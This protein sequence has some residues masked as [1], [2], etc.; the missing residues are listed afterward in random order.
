MDAVQDDVKVSQAWP[1][2]CGGCAV[3]EGLSSLLL[4]VHVRQTSLASVLCQVCTLPEA[5]ACALLA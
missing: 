4:A 3:N 5:R 2:V 1:S